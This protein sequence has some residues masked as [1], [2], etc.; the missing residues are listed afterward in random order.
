MKFRVAVTSGGE[1]LFA[2][3]SQEDRPVYY[4]VVPET[5]I[6]RISV[7]M[8]EA[9]VAA[10]LDGRS[11][12]TSVTEFVFGLEIANLEEWGRWFKETHEYMSYRPKTKQFVSVAQ[13]EWNEVKDLAVAEQLTVLGVALISSI[14]RIGS[15]RRKPKDFDFTALAAS[16]RDVLSRCDSAMVAA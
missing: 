11:F 10:E 12:G 6:W 7:P 15:L 1:V 4:G 8:F 3:Q 9:L 2:G 14:E 13:I 16:V 5:G